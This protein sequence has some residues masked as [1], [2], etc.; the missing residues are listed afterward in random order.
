MRLVLHKLVHGLFLSTPSARRATTQIAAVAEAYPISIHALREEGDGWLSLGRWPPSNFYPR[1][2]RGGRLKL[3]LLYV[4]SP[5]IS[6]HA[7]REEGD[8]DA[9]AKLVAAIRFLST[10]SARRATQ[11]RQAFVDLFVISIHALREEGDG[12]CDLP[13]ETR[14]VFL[15]TP[16]ARRATRLLA[17]L[18]T[19]DTFLSTPSA[20][21]ATGWQRL[22]PGASSIS[23][24]A[25]R[26]EGD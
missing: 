22:Q 4:R 12:E 23:I 11:V 2:P 24:H 16:S 7:L 13:D 5:D 21:R 3:C 18:S 10:P 20:R 6:I 15:S 19:R 25:L 17:A 26:E 14:R 9:K 8:A 1:P